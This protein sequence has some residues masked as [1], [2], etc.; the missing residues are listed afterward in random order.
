MA[1]L[2]FDTGALIGI[3]RRDRRLS[4]LLERAARDGVDVVT[5]SACVAQAWRDPVRQVRL[6][7]A[8]AGIRERP[9]D[10][11]AARRIGGLLG[12]SGTSDVADAAVVLLAGDGDLLVTSDPDDLQ[13]LA[14]AANLD[15]RVMAI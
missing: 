12:R 5:S 7:R 14:D 11:E 15:I 13:R 2:I 4:G 6:A 9:L 1:A 3:E 8:L 10:P